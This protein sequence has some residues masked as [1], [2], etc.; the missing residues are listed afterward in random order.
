MILIEDGELDIEEND[1]I[2]RG[3]PNGKS[4]KYLVIDRGF[5]RVI[6]SFPNHYQTK[7]KKIIES[8]VL[9][10]KPQNTTSSNYQLRIKLF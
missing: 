7:V 3:L 10:N 8:P 6:G 2:Q 5:M 4:E 9:H 1:T